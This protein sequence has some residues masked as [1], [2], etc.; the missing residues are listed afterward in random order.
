ML[1]QTPGPTFDPERLASA[2][3]QLPPSSW[4]VPHKPDDPVAAGY[5]FASL[6]QAGQ[7]K[8]AAGPF[9]FV[10]LKFAP[11][12][13]AWIA[14]VPPH[15]RI[16]P[17]IDQGPYHERWHVPI[18]PAGTFDGAECEA[19]VSFPVAHWAPHQVDNPTDSDRIHLVIDRAVWVDVP[20]APYQRLE[21]S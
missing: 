9:K 4:A 14:K 8:A 16:A 3:A 2:F 10:L 6:V 21:T 13:T 20:S 5:H 18:H 11:I 15:G 12:H 7:Y 19:G 17:H 1:P